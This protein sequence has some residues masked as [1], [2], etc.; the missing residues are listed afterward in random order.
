MNLISCDNCGV[1]LDVN[2]LDFPD[3]LI[4][5]PGITDM[6]KAIWIGD[7]YVSYINCPVCRSSICIDD[8]Q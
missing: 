8:S 1:V 2:K 3:D 4:L 5:E 7:K 6:S